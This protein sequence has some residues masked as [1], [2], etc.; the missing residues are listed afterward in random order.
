M[1]VFKAAWQRWCARED[2]AHYTFK[3][4]IRIAPVSTT[5]E[6]TFWPALLGLLGV[7][8]G[9]WVP[10]LLG[11]SIIVLAAAVVPFLQDFRVELAARNGRR[12]H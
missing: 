9:S 11:M 10:F 2:G 3:R 12:H 4:E 6:L 1:S 5:I 8:L 7:A